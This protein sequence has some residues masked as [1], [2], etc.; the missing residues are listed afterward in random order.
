M[1]VVSALAAE[2]ELLVNVA[3]YW[4]SRYLCDEWQVPEPVN[5][6]SKSGLEPKKK[7][8]WQTAN[9]KHSIFI[10]LVGDELKVSAKSKIGKQHIE[11]GFPLVIRTSKRGLED[12]RLADYVRDFINGFKNSDPLFAT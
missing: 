3:S 2:R 8:V 7:L 1:G 11:Q 12:N 9:G 5:E 4:L 6:W 10:E